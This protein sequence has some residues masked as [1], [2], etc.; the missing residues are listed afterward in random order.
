MVIAGGPTFIPQLLRL[1]GHEEEAVRSEA[2]RAV[3]NLCR[4]VTEVTA[5]GQLLGGIPALVGLLK[6]EHKILVSE[7]TLALVAL[8]AQHHPDLA[9]AIQ[10]ANTLDSALECLALRTEPTLTCNVL[11]LVGSLGQPS[12]EDGARVGA[13]LEAVAH[14]D[15]M[16]AEQCDKVRQILQ[17]GSS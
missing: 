5:V 10:A 6:S 7:A 16:I 1:T 15:P 4:H 2:I 14:K 9:A 11:T 3:G 12:V 17:L 8:V 13:A